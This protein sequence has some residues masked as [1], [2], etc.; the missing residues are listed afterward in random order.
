MAKRI[1]YLLL[2]LHV[3][4]GLVIVVQVY[5]ETYFGLIGKGVRENKETWRTVI[6]LTFGPMFGL[7]G[8]IVCLAMYAAMRNVYSGRERVRYLGY[9]VFG[10]PSC[11]LLACA[12]FASISEH[13]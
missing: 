13:L 10:P 8:L 9:A 11:F 6:D 4:T 3:L 2:A 7:W 12:V 1:H 5:A